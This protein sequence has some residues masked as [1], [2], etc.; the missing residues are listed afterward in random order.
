MKEV[1]HTRHTTLGLCIAFLVASIGCNRPSPH[2]EGFTFSP[3]NTYLA[4]VYFRGGKSFIYKVPLDT[5]KAV[6]LTKAR[7]MALR[8]FLHFH[9]MESELSIHTRIRTED[10]RAS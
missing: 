1:F 4:A 7:L 9:R 2:F 5:G 8:E 6:R 10:I 3:D